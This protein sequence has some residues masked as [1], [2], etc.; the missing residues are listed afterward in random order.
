MLA[1]WTE[2]HVHLSNPLPQR[3]SKSHLEGEGAEEQEAYGT[4]K[5]TQ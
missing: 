1:Q 2:L 5:V 4:F 3:H